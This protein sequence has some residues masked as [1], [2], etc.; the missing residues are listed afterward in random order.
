[1]GFGTGH[2]ATT[3]L[4]LLALQA[5]PL[6]GARALDVGTGSGVLAIAAVRLGA[7]SAVGIDDDPDAVQATRDNLVLNAVDTVTLATSAVWPSNTAKGLS[8]PDRHKATR[9]SSPPVMMLLSGA[10]ATAF[11]ALS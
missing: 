1:M 6:A 2:H 10:N 3:R 9:P 5:V 8:E 4:C 7:A 11:T